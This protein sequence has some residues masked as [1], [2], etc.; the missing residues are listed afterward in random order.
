M[1]C[2]L[3]RLAREIETSRREMVQLASKASLT[4]R[5]VIEASTKLDSLLNTY[6][7]MINQ[8]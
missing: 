2:Q 6:H 3:S 4:D 5:N 7:L 8:K 1:H